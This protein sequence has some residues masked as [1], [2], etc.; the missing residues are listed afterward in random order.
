M[1]I[2]K[3]VVIALLSLVVSS[4]LF[5][6][7][8]NHPYPRT[9]VFHFGR[10]VPDWYARFD[11][12]DL[13]THNESVVKATKAINP[14]TIMLPTTGW[15]AWTPNYTEWYP[16]ET[17]SNWLVQTSKGEDVAVEWQAYLVNLSNFCPEV[18]GK[19]YN[20][21]FPEF[22]LS[23]LI[24]V[25]VYDGLASDWLWSKPHNVSD[26]DFDMNGVNDYE[27]HGAAWVEKIWLEGVETMLSNFRKLISDDKLL[28]INSGLFQEWGWEHTNGP[29]LEY[30]S[31]ISDWSYF[32]R[33]YTDFMDNAREPH[34]MIMDVK[35]DGGDSFR[36]DEDKN[37]FQLMRFMLTATMLGDGYFD[38]ADEGSGHHYH[39][40]YDEFD[41][42]LGYPR[43][44]GVK[45]SNGCY[46]RFFDNG[47]SVINPT[48]TSRVVR[49]EDLRSISV[50]DGP[51]YR[52]IGGQAPDYN[53]GQQFTNIRLWGD[54]DS[55]DGKKVYGD[56]IILVKEPAVVVA[57]II[58]D[59]LDYGTSPSSETVK[60][61]G[62]W[63]QTDEGDNSWYII[64]RA[65]S[66]WYPHA[67]VAPGNGDATAQFVPN[68]GV[69]GKYEVFEWHGTLSVKVASNAP[70]KIVSTDGVTNL[71]INQ[72]NNVG[73]WNSLGVYEFA[74][75]TKGM[76]EL[77]NNANGVVLADAVMF[78]SLDSNSGG[79]VEIDIT[80]PRPPQGIKVDYEGN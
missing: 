61:Q 25:T 40:Y 75:G 24:D 79:K 69:A 3:H 8:P 30:W 63:Q 55:R 48:G 16:P 19:K 14:T 33:V 1:N 47:V 4:S 45:L 5:G 65:R 11:L 29:I 12:V 13:S 64:D 10:A 51:Y 70:C 59:N 71:T 72:S 9:A 2:K 21:R 32:W 6:Q 73:K 27:E 44:A 77:N 58:I 39:R 23:D 54:V 74:R 49:D 36:P 56:G 76:V 60:L 20:E 18:N 17:K 22:L 26:V 57:D 15:T 43:S 66:G 31:G 7:L 46:A 38:F 28:L 37:Y 78:V 62:G 41:V 50:Y 35:V 53:N 67:F 80:P 42:Q 34:V 68:I 52:F